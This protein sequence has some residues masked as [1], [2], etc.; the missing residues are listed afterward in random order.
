MQ[1]MVEDGGS[2][3]VVLSDYVNDPEGEV[4]MAS[5]SG[6]TQGPLWSDRFCYLRRRIDH[7]ATPQYER[8]LSASPVGWGWR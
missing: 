5:I 2:T 3:S 1:N 4:L 8:G 6:Q 7:H